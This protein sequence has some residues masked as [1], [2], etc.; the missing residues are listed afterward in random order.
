MRHVREAVYEN[1]GI[2]LEA[3]VRLIGCSLQE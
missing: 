2:L 3:E 1:S